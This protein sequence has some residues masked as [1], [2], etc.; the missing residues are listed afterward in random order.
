[1][2]TCV[3]QGL[4]SVN[5]IT[6]AEFVNRMDQLFDIMNSLSPRAR[7]GKEAIT[8]A[9]IDQKFEVLDSAMSWIES[10]TFQD[11]KSAQMPFQKGWLITIANM[12]RVVR[13]LLE[14]GFSFVATR[15]LNQDCLEV[16]FFYAQL[17]VTH[18]LQQI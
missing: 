18:N 6:T 5:A 4:T 14:R 3:N 11:S 12:K 10:W 17:T 2:M 8:T 13:D 9:N 16:R 1:M 15:R 7:P